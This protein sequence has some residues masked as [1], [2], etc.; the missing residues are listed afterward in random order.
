MFSSSGDREYIISRRALNAASE[1]FAQNERLVV[2][3]SLVEYGDI[4]WY[5]SG[6][7]SYEAEREQVEKKY[8]ERLDTN[9]EF[10]FWASFSTTFRI[11]TS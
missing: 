7:R 11:F 5:Q 6:A 1:I 4:V 10:V 2:L 3:F 9:G 8:G